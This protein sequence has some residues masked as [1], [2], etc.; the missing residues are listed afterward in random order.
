MATDD[1]NEVYLRRY[2]STAIKRTK[3]KQDA[4]DRLESEARK[5]KLL[6]RMLTEPFLRQAC[7]LAIENFATPPTGKS[8]KPVRQSEPAQ[9]Q[10]GARL[11]FAADSLM[12]FR[13]L[14]GLPLGHAMKGDVVA[15]AALY[16]RIADSKRR[17]AKWLTL[18]ADKMPDNKVVGA[19]FTEGDLKRLKKEARCD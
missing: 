2:I 8:S 19:V 15:T 9:D 10:C 1:A 16:N 11:R 13:L 6:W 4:V 14:D 5:D 18:I 17:R 3:T 7:Q 12:G